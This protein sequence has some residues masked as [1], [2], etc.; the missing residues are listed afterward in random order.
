M[1]AAA[2]TGAV[3]A[4][5]VA[6]VGLGLVLLNT[7]PAHALEARLVSSLPLAGG[8][9]LNVKAIEGSIW[10]RMSLDQVT[11]TDPKGVFLVSPRVVL[12][13]NPWALLHRTIELREASTD[14]LRLLRRPVFT[15]SSR[16]R[17]RM[18][19]P[20]IVAPRVHL[21][22][23]WLEPAV[24]GERR[25]LRADAA[26]VLLRGRA[27]ADL[28]IL[29][30]PIGVSGRADSLTLRVD[31]EPALNRLMLEGHLEALVGG[32]VDRLTGLGRPLSADL[33]GTGS[34]SSWTGS[35]DAAVGSQPL[36]QAS[37][38]ARSG[39][40]TINGLA[41][42][43]V[44]SSG[45]LAALTKPR[46]AFG[47]VF[48]VANRVV[49]GAADLRS[50]AFGFAANGGLD[51]QHS[52]FIGVTLD[53]RLVDPHTLA[54]NLSGRDVRMQARLDG[55]FRHAAATYRMQAASL[56]LGRRL[57][58][59]LQASGQALPEPSGGWTARF[60]ASASGIDGA[61]AAAAALSRDLQV[62]G[63]VKLTGARVVSKGLTVASA[64]LRARADLDLDFGASL[65]HAKVQARL[66][67]LPLQGVGLVD[68]S[69]DLAVAATGPKQIKA[70]G[71]LKARSVR[72]DNPAASKLLGGNAVIEARV[73]GGGPA[74]I[75]LTSLT[76][77][78]PKFRILTGHGSYSPSGRIALS[79][80][81]VST[82]YGPLKLQVSG[83]LAA[84]QATLHADDL[85]V[86][87]LMAVDVRLTGEG[88]GRYAVIVH[89][90]S[91]YGPV[92]ADLG[93]TLGAGQ[94]QAQVRDAEFAGVRLQG[95]VS[96]TPA[97]PFSG[98]LVLS[99]RGISGTVGLSPAGAVQ[100]ADV[101]LRVRQASLPLQPPVTIAAGTL[102]ARL[103]LRPGSTSANGTAKLTG[104]RRG[105]LLVTKAA[106]DVDY[107]GGNGTASVKLAGEREVPFT[108]DL[109][110]RLSPSTLTL[111]ASGAVDRIP[112]R[113]VRPAVVRIAPGSYRLESATLDS[114]AGRIEISGSYASSG[115]AGQVRLAQLDL[116]VAR[117]VAPGLGLGGRASG[118][119]DLTL[120]KGAPA[121]TARL[122][123][124]LDRFTRS[125]AAEVSTP[126]D[127]TVAADLD[128]G[129]LQANA[130]LK[131][132]GAVIGRAQA[133][134]VLGPA[135]RRSWTER[136]RSGAL[137]GGVRFNGDAQTLWSLTGLA[138]ETISGPIAI[139]ADVSGSL[140][141]PQLR[142]LVQAKSLRFQD[143]K[144]GAAVDGIAIDARFTGPRLQ[145]DRLTGR[146]GEGSLSAS[147]Y[148]DL[149]AAAG[150]P[151][152][153]Q[154]RL[155]EARLV[156]GD[157]LGA[158]IS[159]QLSVVNGKTGGALVSGDLTLNRGRY[160]IVRQGK[161]QIVELSGVHRAGEPLRE[162]Q[163]S[164]AGTTHAGFLRQWRLDVQVHAPQ[165]LYVRGLGLDSEWRTD[166]RITGSLDHP[167]VVGD[168]TLVRGTF[169]FAGRDLTLSRG[170]IHLNGSEPPN[171]TL[172]LEATATVEDV[173]ATIDIGGTASHP[174]ISFSSSPALPQDEVLSR[175]L[176]GSSVGQLSAVQA[177]QLAASLNALRSG[178][179]G[180][181][182]IGKL[183][184]LTGIDELKFYAADQSSG[185]GAALGVGKHIAKNLYVELTTD[186]QGY[187]AT[188]IDFALTRTLSL[189]SRVGT[190]GGTDVE[191]RYSHRY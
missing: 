66:Q 76:V 187:T 118:A 80:A 117:V 178:G 53:A 2:W 127:V 46:L 17:K 16:P 27:Q 11:V 38:K 3:L 30:Q 190:F 180:F 33:S 48:S 144:Y 39:R 22:T 74:G 15:A 167:R 162:V 51:L 36:L 87:G 42:P 166:L 109:A 8:V 72:L 148:A 108:L 20:N 35:A 113:L 176:F 31:A 12:D 75:A 85:G 135:D 21:G 156:N 49:A 186:A 28:D 54:S 174:E 77:M 146:A 152:N 37:V 170:L 78:A 9:R 103:L 14:V 171:P 119:L 182:P 44:V 179:G 106:L 89:G 145:I 112:V 157:D 137:T 59:N 61:G 134:L 165:Q 169:S 150:F 188:Q 158:T 18:T 132:S 47:V 161:D 133:R 104:V 60:R 131:R 102:K 125:T 32:L 121:P 191:L 62:G 123:L 56:G 67:R 29:A 92:A 90:A 116:G 71:T 97:G 120:P 138:D 139:G 81:A 140:A 143:A 128:P 99:G 93:L 86:A 24:T 19:L 107:A 25:R 7:P 82:D 6:L 163:A 159:G 84:P 122:R 73:G 101:A 10:G 160:Q 183:R 189:L 79:A 153:L 70:S 34:W 114:R 69:A 52:R 155:D 164:Q 68:A 57:V 50:A 55:D 177:V 88:S 95:M 136:L 13:W 154:I 185:R 5:L 126:V 181:N 64:L 83:T 110:A 105:D 58:E 91:R 168:I 65:Y 172:D 149:S 40:F 96:R 63:T 130:L 26:L 115:A 100:A 23:L 151:M 98:T 94:L 4:G 173:T 43:A 124:Q 111:D 141:Q 184:Q 147:G 129:V 45:P 175:L 142:G 1:K 41:Y